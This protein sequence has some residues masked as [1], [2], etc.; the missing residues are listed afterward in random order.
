MRNGT[1]F[2]ERR[3]HQRFKAQ[4]HAFAVLES[5]FAK[6]G[7]IINISR[8]GLAFCYIACGGKTTQTTGSFEVD[9]FLSG[10]DFYLKKVSAKIVSDSEVDNKIS[11]SSLGEQIK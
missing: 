8:G 5:N 2:I 4:K 3:K 11:F 1:D 9:I 7:L 6:L 10:N